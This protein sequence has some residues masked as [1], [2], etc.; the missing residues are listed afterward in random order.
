VRLYINIFTEV[1]LGS[2][3]AKSI[4]CDERKLC[5]R[6]VLRIGRGRELGGGECIKD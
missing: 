4:I 3:G 5:I 2:Y 6:S 1:I